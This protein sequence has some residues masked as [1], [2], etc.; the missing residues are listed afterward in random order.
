MKIERA[1]VFF[2]KDA[3]VGDLVWY[4]DGNRD[5]YDDGGKRIGRGHYRLEPVAEITKKYIRIGQPGFLKDFDK[6]RGNA[7]TVRGYQPP[8]HIFGELEKWVE[9]HKAEIYR[10]C[11]TN[12]TRTLLRIAE[13][14]GIRGPWG[15]SAETDAVIEFS[16]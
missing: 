2:W 8:D 9:Q 15:E 13:A 1:T 16:R 5:V 14:V 10:R 3:Q 11:Q 12:D 7:R 4:R 6:E